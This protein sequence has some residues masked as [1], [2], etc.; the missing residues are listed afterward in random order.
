[1]ATTPTLLKLTKRE[2]AAI[3]SYLED[4]AAAPLPPPP[5][6]RASTKPAPQ[7]NGDA[8]REGRRGEAPRLTNHNTR[9][10]SAARRER[11]DY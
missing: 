6:S 3:D 2:R 9:V 10:M 1:M 11:L 8:S 7:P 5:P 4:Q